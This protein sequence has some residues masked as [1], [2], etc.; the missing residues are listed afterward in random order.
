MDDVLL[1][2]RERSGWHICAV[3]APYTEAAGSVWMLSDEWQRKQSGISPMTKDTTVQDIPAMTAALRQ[4]RQPVLQG[5]VLPPQPAQTARP[6]RIKVKKYGFLGA[7][8]RPI[9]IAI[10]LLLLGW[11]SLM[12]GTTYYRSYQRHV[13]FSKTTHGDQ[14][15]LAVLLGQAGP[16]LSTGET[17]FIY[18]DING[19]LHRVVA[20]KSAVASFI[21]RTLVDL[22]N[23]QDHIMAGVDNEL[24]HIFDTAFKDRQRAIDDY[25]DWFFEWKR[26]YVILKEAIKSTANR[27]LET[28]KYESL[29]EAVEHDVKDYFMKNY[30]ERVLKPEMRDAVIAAKMEK[31]VRWAHRRYKRAIVRSDRRLQAFLATQTR[32]LED[33]PDDQKATRLALDWD[34]QKWKSPHY[35]AEDRAFD[36][37]VGVG[38]IAAGG[39]FGALALGPLM[40]R[41]VGASF[42]ALSRSVVTSMGS[43]IALTEGGAAAGTAAAPGVGTAVGTAA[44]L[45]IGAAADYFLNKRREKKNRAKFIQSNN[46]ALDLTI[47][48]W[49]GKLRANVGGAVKR[50]FD[51][52]RAGMILSRS[53]GQKSAPAA[54]RSNALSNT[55]ML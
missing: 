52:A 40:T 16:A 31:L 12:I 6:T 35:L 4:A 51:D 32:V 10:A 27:M 50:W 41:T 19:K 26:S 49:K 2:A 28:G 23:E 11:G 14:S 39:T 18:R 33:F 38:R 47:S 55:P 53:K 9:G 36:G 45:V 54:D 44:G 15:Y 5:E 1:P 17:K 46:Q 42:G 24:D 21:N 13:A 37:V 34:A 3:K 29:K 25:A 8:L 20:A 43:R 7:F 48:Q 22:D 30:N